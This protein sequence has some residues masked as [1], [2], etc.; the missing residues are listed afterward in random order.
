MPICL[1]ERLKAQ[2]FLEGHS[3]FSPVWKVKVP[4]SLYKQ[5]EDTGIQQSE[6]KVGRQVILHFPGSFLHLGHSWMVLPTVC[7]GVLSP[8]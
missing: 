8:Q 5:K 7:G 4:E 2:G 3:S 6:A 1:Q